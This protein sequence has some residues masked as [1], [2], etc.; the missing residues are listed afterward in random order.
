MRRGAAVGE[1][2]IQVEVRQRQTGERR[3]QV[4]A[5]VDA[6]G[7]VE[8]INPMTAE[9]AAPGQELRGCVAKDA[10]LAVVA[11]VEILVARPEQGVGRTLARM[12]AVF[13]TRMNIKRVVVFVI[14][15]QLPQELDLL[16]R[17]S[18]CD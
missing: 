5:G 6:D 1:C 18:L 17:N 11:L 15:R 4:V 14:Q 3:L 9:A 13:Q 7:A 10:G 8:K 2:L 12:F 16:I